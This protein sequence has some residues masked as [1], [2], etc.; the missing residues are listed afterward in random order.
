MD[1]SVKWPVTRGPMMPEWRVVHVDTLVRHPEHVPFVAR[2]VWREF[3]AEV[4]DGLTEAY[5]AEAFAGQAEPGRVLLSLMAL[6]QDKP[7]GCVHLIDNDDDSLPE[8]HP[9]LAAMVVVPERRG[10]GIGSMLVRALAHE[11]RV[12]GFSQLWLGTDSPG[13]YERLGA[14]QHLCK[15]RAFRIMR[16][17]LQASGQ[18]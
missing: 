12:M 10:Q 7:L 18:G 2:L 14:T 15:G 13:F 1:R 11:A 3:W 5:L 6:E 8:L 16:L 4:P 9:W 17:K